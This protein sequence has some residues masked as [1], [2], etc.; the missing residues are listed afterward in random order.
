MSDG[1]GFPSDYAMVSGVWLGR[2]RLNEQGTFPVEVVG[3]GN[4]PRGGLGST[5]EAQAILVRHASQLG[6]DA[7]WLY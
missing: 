2:V 5:G 1:N 4:T 7:V 3:L 6:P